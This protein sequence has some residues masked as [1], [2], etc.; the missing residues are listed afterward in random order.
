[1][2]S[3]VTRSK[4]IN[5]TG[6]NKN[7]PPRFKQDVQEKPHNDGKK[8]KS[9]SIRQRTTQPL[10]K[11]QQSFIPFPNQIRSIDQYGVLVLRIRSIDQYEVLSSCVEY[12]SQCKEKKDFSFQLERKGHKR[13]SNRGSKRKVES[14]IAP[15]S[16]LKESMCFYCK[17]K[18]HWKG[19]CLKYLKDLKDGKVKKGSHSG[20]KE[21]RRLK[22]GELNLVM[23]CEVFVRREAQ[24]KL[25]AISEKCLFVGFLE[26]SFGYLFYKTKDNVVCVARRGVFLEREM[27]SKEDSESKIDLEEIQESTNEEPIVNTDTQQEVKRWRK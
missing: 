18:G 1:M 7:E 26:E 25:E 27:I 13:K 12:W 17:T 21:S 20:L 16:N 11:P 15:T 6:I 2:M 14:E 8:N 23:G 19:S 4:E 22:R 9:S 10:V 24:D 5:E 3:E